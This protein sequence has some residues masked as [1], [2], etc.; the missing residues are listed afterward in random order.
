MKVDIP[1]AREIFLTAVE[2]HSHEQWSGYLD[3]AC[4]D[5]VDLRRRVEALLRAHDATAGVID[6]LVQD[7]D[8]PREFVRSGECP[9]AAI[10][11]YEL[12]EVIGEG[13]MGVVYRAE[14][15]TPVKRTVALKIIKPGMDSAQVVARFEAE[16]QALALMDHPNIARVVDAG[17]TDSGRPYFVMELVSGIPITDYCDENRRAIPERLE[18]F[19][20]VC[21]AVQHAHQKG[22]I[23]RDL[24]PSNVL[25]TLQDGVP[26]PKVI[27]FGI[28]KATGPRLTDQSTTMTGLA[29]IVGT[30]LY[31]SPEQAELNGRDIDTRSDVY[32]LG[33]LL[34]ELLTGTTPFEP[35][36]F[37]KAALGE[38]CRIVREHEPPRPSTRLSTLTDAD[39]SNVSANRQTDP[40]RLS[41]T[42]HGELD[43]IVMK[44]LEK[45]R[46]RRY[47]T[48]SALADDLMRFLTDRPV[49]AC[50]PSAWYRF[51]KYARRNR[52]VMVATG[53][54][55]LAL[56][57]GTSVSTW[58]VTRATAAERRTR[59]HLE[60][61][62]QAVDDLYGEAAARWFGDIRFGP[63]PRPFLEKALPFYRRFAESR[64]V[65]PQTGRAYQRVGE[66]LVQLGRWNEADQAYQ[67]ARAIFEALRAV[68]PEN[69]DC[70][71]DLAGCDETVAAYRQ[72]APL[73]RE[74][75]A[76][77]ETLAARFPGNRLYQE[78]LAN[79]IDGLCDLLWW[80]HEPGA[81]EYLDRVLK[82][83]ERLYAADP[84]NPD[85][86]LRLADAMAGLG[87][88]CRDTNRL[89]EAER[90]GRQSLE[91]RKEL[92]ATF[93][94]RPSHWL[95]LG[96]S[97]M[98]LGMTLVAA[99]KYEE[100]PAVSGRGA[101]IFEGLAADYHDIGFFP[102]HQGRCLR[103]VATALIQTG[104]RA[105][106]EPVLRKLEGIGNGRCA[107]AFLRDIANDLCYGADPRFQHTD[108]AFELLDRSMKLWPEDSGLVAHLRG[109]AHYRAGNLDTALR[110]LLQACAPRSDDESLGLDAHP[111]G[112]LRGA[113][114]TP[115]PDDLHRGS[116]FFLAMIYHKK[117]DPVR[118]RSWFDRSAA[119]MRAHE[120]NDR[121]LIVHRA[122]AAALLGLGPDTMPKG[123]RA[124]AP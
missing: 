119:W 47:E 7:T 74:A 50:P 124:F 15:S 58:Q 9:G 38:I 25:V 91:I 86:R 90:Y 96:W 46:A 89:A 52:G 21:R 66:I 53:L 95:Y 8:R 36:T 44:C 109:V 105:E 20:L 49:E 35:E 70:L 18:L 57:A 113:T 56:I 28:A 16:R 76:L 24:K 54:V 23:H 71:R 19:V 84:T 32:S 10:G 103:D 67:K 62:R 85:L 94:T 100:I 51:T 108:L 106:A 6:Q 83:R 111:E 75:I 61:A 92:N 122:K 102:D 104:R 40:R 98:D 79:S 63:L 115:Q 12:L 45:E 55:A 69:P 14:Q 121:F 26:V 37:R 68:D 22:I 5:D 116:G 4:A 114:G 80:R 110:E 34:Y 27:D 107:A 17:S 101:A 78:E 93:F 11:P 33:V 97:H 118:A 117:G 2:Y 123:E 112:E 82:I 59:E 1:R 39:R 3:E 72:R 48:V 99:R 31:M 30:P 77:R 81:E 29:Q 64:R 42:I 120:P 87:N 43:W 41:R 65:D 13:G 73:F 88:R 60:L